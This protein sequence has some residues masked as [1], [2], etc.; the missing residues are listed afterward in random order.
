VTDSARRAD[1]AHRADSARQAELTTRLA[2]VRARIARAADAVGR[3]P[4]SITLVVVTKTW[5]A[6]D[7]RLLASLGVRDVGENRDQEAAPKAA[8]C[9]DL[10]D[11]RW[12]FIGQLQTN[13]AASVARYARAVHSVDRL[14]LVGALDRGAAAAGRNVG[15]LVQVSL[16]LDTGRGGADI[17]DV[18]S[19]ADAIGA[20]NHLELLGVM[21]VAPLNTDPAEAFDRLARVAV[22]LQSA[23]PS[24]TWVSAGMSADLEA[25]VAAGATHVRVG[26]AVLGSRPKLG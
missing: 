22:Q 7:V 9:A 12:H 1:S 8:E 16:D 2:E 21:A 10:A 5:P 18:P 24:A 25:A 14:R 15:A 11:L 20:S 13:K 19:I 26:S 4:T 6:S 23:H 17:A 3:P